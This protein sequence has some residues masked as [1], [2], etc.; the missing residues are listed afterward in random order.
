MGGNVLYP[1]ALTGKQGEDKKKKIST[2]KTV[3]ET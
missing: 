2:L 3:E 1:L